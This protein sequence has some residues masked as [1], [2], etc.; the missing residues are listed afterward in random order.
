MRHTLAVALLLAALPAGAQPPPKPPPPVKSAGPAAT[1][2]KSGKTELT[3][4]GH[5]AFKV[6]TP[7]G[8]VLLIDPWL[9][10]PT[11][12]DGKK[13]V[14]DPG[15]VDAILITHGHSDHVGD[16]VAL[17]KKTRALL[18]SSFDLGQAVVAAGYPK[19]QAGYATQGNTGGTISILDGEVEVTMTPAV[20]S[21]TFSANDKG[22]FD[23]LAPGGNPQGFVIRVKN[24]PSIY[25]AGDTDLFGDMKLIGP[26]S[27]MLAPIGDHFTM[28]PDRAAQA[29]K[30]VNPKRVIPMHFGTFPVLTGTPEA[31]KAAVK[32]AG[33]KAEVVVLEVNKPMPL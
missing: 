10:N 9:Q 33:S 7:S 23:S 22:T 25:H 12:P 16:A 15:Q 29:V 4:L 8:K 30:L 13:L 3:W 2:P 6:Q 27:V 14:D 26:V 28:G 5:A 19:D 21:S 24:G 31:F 17:G 18:V 32:K 1:L 20:H 11:N